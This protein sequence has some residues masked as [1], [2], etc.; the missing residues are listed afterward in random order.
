MKY[1]TY[2]I[3][4]LGYEILKNSRALLQ[5][6]IADLDTELKVIKRKT[7]LVIPGGG[8]NVVSQREGEEVALVLLGKGYNVY[9]LKYTSRTEDSTVVFPQQLLEALASIKFIKDHS[10]ENYAS[11][12]INLVGFSA[13]GH[14]AG[15]IGLLGNNNEFKSM[16]GL[17]KYDFTITSMGLIYAV[18]SAN[19][20][21]HLGTYQNS[22]SSKYSKEFLSLD[23][24]VTTSS[25]RLFMASTSNDDIVNIQNSL[26]IS[27]KYALLGNNFELHV[28]EKGPHGF[29]LA[30]EVLQYKAG[31]LQKYIPFWIELYDD[32][33]KR[34]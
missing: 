5:E 9:L 6:Y 20:S 7:I 16:L 2:K 23:Q 8:Y 29:S 4:K 15:C 21:T 32:F 18:I 14:L 19:I 26:L 28:F 30:N 10:K 27:T 31:E 22:V 24:Y 17:S 1:N 13:G 34:S 3:N 33:L 25:P 11:E 12:E